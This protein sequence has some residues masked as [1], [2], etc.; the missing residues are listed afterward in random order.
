VEKL[1]ITDIQKDNEVESPDDEIG[2]GEQITKSKKKRNRKK[3]AAPAGNVKCNF[4]CL[5]SRRN[6]F[7]CGDIRITHN[8]I[9]AP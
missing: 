1:T 2:S 8:L 9:R 3:K 4:F 6:Y 5:D 7:C